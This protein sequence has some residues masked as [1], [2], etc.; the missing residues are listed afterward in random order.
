MISKTSS[1]KSSFSIE[2]LSD[3]SNVEGVID[4][5]SIQL[6][7][8]NRRNSGELKLQYYFDT[9]D[10]VNLIRG[11]LEYADFSRGFNRE[12][13]EQE[14]LKNLVYALAFQG[15]YKP[16]SIRMLEPHKLE[17]RI[18]ASSK[19]SM[20][21]LNDEDREALFNEALH[22]LNSNFTEIDELIKNNNRKQLIRELIENSHA[23]FIIN[24]LLEKGVSWQRRLSHLK[25]KGIVI[26][27]KLENELEN[28]E[29]AELFRT[30]SA[31]FKNARE[32]NAYNNLYDSLA[33]YHLQ[34]KLDKYNENN[35]NPLPVFLASTPTVKKA[36]QNITKINPNL[37]S[38]PVNPK[39]PNSKRITIVRDFLFFAL[40]PIF[41]TRSNVKELFDNLEESRPV[42]RN[43]LEQEYNNAFNNSERN[44]V[45]IDLRRVIKRFENN[46]SNLIKTKFTQE[47]WMK[48]KIYEKLIDDIE[49]ECVELIKWTQR[50]NDEI[51]QKIEEELEEILGGATIGIS[52]TRQLTVIIKSFENAKHDFDETF[53]QE[54]VRGRLDV[55]KDFALMKFGIDA[56]LIPDLSQFIDSISINEDLSYDSPELY[57]LLSKLSVKVKDDVSAKTFLEGITV[58]WMLGKNR[59]ITELCNPLDN[60]FF[61][62]QYP[63]ALIYAA[64]TVEVD[65]SKKGEERVNEVI[66]CVLGKKSENY[67][68]WIGVAYLFNRLWEHNNKMYHELPEMD[69]KKWKSITKDNCY[70]EYFLN[71]TQKYI[72]QAYEYLKDK[73]EKEKDSEFYNIYL[74]YYLYTLNNVIYYN[75]KNGTADEFKKLPEYVKEFLKYEEVETAWQGRFYDTLGWYSLRS[76]YYIDNSRLKN[77]YLDRVLDYLKQAKERIA[78]RRDRKLYKQLE[79][80]ILLV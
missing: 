26:F 67:K 21:N 39:D 69:K 75:S 57:G 64:A 24:F 5:Y 15:A 58:A 6:L 8:E 4:S 52:R 11:G 55:F 40:E 51:N 12:K 33:F 60:F 32:S 17:F 27:E 45:R 38:Y 10:V 74:N 68:V 65:R 19:E 13:Y 77:L 49:N 44:T 48:E 43:L 61:R 30:I 59:L 28:I 42:I 31:G 71:G 37:F 78:T 46:I 23:F 73:I 79:D 47:I 80:A 35:S 20:G 1:I 25:K 72:F 18:K 3:L 34:K 16:T 41:S 66:E 2:V 63:T 36:I 9:F 50:E 62:D 54:N 29:D 22:Y 76:Y 56:R 70:K 14:E 7:E 53:R